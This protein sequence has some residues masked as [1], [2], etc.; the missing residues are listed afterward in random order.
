MLAL[1]NPGEQRFA[2]GFWRYYETET[3]IATQI[4]ALARESG[5]DHID[6]AD[7]YGC[8]GGQGEFGGAE[9]LLGALRKSAPSL[10]DGAVI[11][12]KAGV[13]L[14]TPYNNS[15]EYLA[16]ACDASL[17]RLG[18]ERVDLF[19]VHRH[20][21]LAHP[22]DVARALEKLVAAG[23]IG[24]IGVS[25]YT[26]AQVDALAR[27]LS[28]PIRAVQI[29]FSAA[30]VAPIF[31]GALDQAMRAHMHVAAWSPLAGGRLGDDAGE[32]FGPL[33]AKLSEIAARDGASDVGAAL[34]FLM[35]H[36]AGVT[37]ILGTKQ[38]ARLK[39]CLEA[40]KVQLSRQD[41]YRVLEAS[42]GQRMP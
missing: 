28:T 38:P 4:L 37:P 24:A 9:L 8:Y 17:K 40:A 42:L 33:R 6:T 2:Y 31:D 18:V 26:P 10:F 29:E 21:L 11:A 32:A 3:E 27:F 7:V 20:D 15:P 14:G 1:A 36:P 39:A 19:Y 5:I 34:A 13:E 25:N 30:C 41:W 22:E 16:H 12:T 35:R 23:K